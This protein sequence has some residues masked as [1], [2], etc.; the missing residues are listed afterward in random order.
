MLLITCIS[1]AAGHAHL[2]RCWSRSS[3]A[4]LVTRISSAAGHVHLKRCWSRASQA[5]LVTCISSTAG[6]AYV[7]GV[8]IQH[9]TSG[10]VAAGGYIQCAFSKKRGDV[11]ESG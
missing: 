11:M 9:L 7:D 5:L 6:H 1:S 8:H 2:K 4:L 3:Q 10:M